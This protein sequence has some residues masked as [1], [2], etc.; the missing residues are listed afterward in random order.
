V[1]TKIAGRRVKDDD[2]VFA[3]LAV[4]AKT[5]SYFVEVARDPK[6][7]KLPVARAYREPI[8][9]ITAMAPTSAPVVATP[10]ASVADEIAKFAKLRA[11]GV[12]TEE[13]FQAQKRK[14]LGL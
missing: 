11:D 3:A 8:T 10:S 13:E 12:I 1:I 7:V 6:P 2:T 14:L 5:P 9:Q 4:A